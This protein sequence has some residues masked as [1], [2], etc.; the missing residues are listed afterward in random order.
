MIR[1]IY[2]VHES[3][4]RLRLRLPWL[5]QAPEEVDAL[6]DRVAAMEGVEEVRIRPYTGSVLCTFDP[7]AIRSTAIVEAV[8]L[9]TGVRTVLRPGEHDEVEDIALAEAALR[10]GTGLARSVAGMFKGLNLSLLRTTGGRVD[11]GMAAAVTFAGAGVAEVI[12]TR[13]LPM[14][15]WFNLGWWAFRTFM[16]VEKQ[17]IESAPVE[18]PTAAYPHNP[19]NSAAGEQLHAR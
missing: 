13:K 17:A 10:Q 12:V 3:S 19:Q 18:I 2:L 7:H 15:P 11:L 1:V 8:E 9:H 4:G 5:R 14:P 16:T 6:A